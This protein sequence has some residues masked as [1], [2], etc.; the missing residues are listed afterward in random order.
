MQSTREPPRVLLPLRSATACGA[1]FWSLRWRHGCQRSP[2]MPRARRRAS[3]AAWPN[4]GRDA[5]DHRPPAGG[6][7]P[8]GPGHPAP[9]SR[10]GPRPAPASRSRREQALLPALRAGSRGPAYRCCL[11]DPPAAG[12][13]LEPDDGSLAAMHGAIWPPSPR[14]GWAARSGR[15]R[16]PRAPLSLIGVGRGRLWP[17]RRARADPVARQGCRAL[18]S[19]LGERYARHRRGRGWAPQVGFADGLVA[20]LGLVPRRRAGSR[21]TRATSISDGRNAG[22]RCRA[23]G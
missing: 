6:L 16:L 15:S 9:V 4:A 12:T 8:G 13:V 20:T 1:L 22:E 7:R 2:P 18:P 11:R 23:G 14:R 17:I 5:R 21:A 10:P 3:G 19:R